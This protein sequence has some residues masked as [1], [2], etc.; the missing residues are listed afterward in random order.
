[1][2]TQNQDRLRIHFSSVPDTAH[3]DRW[4]GLWKEANFLPWDRGHAN[5]AL[6]DLLDQRSRPLSSPDPNPS[7]GAPPPNSESP[8]YASLLSALTSEGRRRRVLIPGCG[9]GYDVALFAAHGYDASGLEVS[10]HAADAARKYLEDPGKGPVEREYSVR[11]EKIGR[12]AMKVVSGDYF[13]DT[14]LKDVEGWD[15]DEGFDIIYDNTFLCALP[16]TLRP[17]WASRTA[18]LLRRPSP[19]SN[20][21][22]GVLICLEFPTHKPASSGGPPWS[23]PPLVHAELLKRPGQNIQYDDQGVVRKTDTEEMDNA[24]VKITH[25]TPKRTHDIGIIKGLVRD[26]VSM[27][28]HKADC[29][30]GARWH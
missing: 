4:D 7:L 29:P 28:R 14:W 1:M 13:E 18:S 12:G 10:S 27:W 3:N 25:Y 6:I 23:L 17:K 21:S 22:G 2:T 24:L 15:E 30:E 8:G 26:C 20:L 16:P 5:P 9:K 19:N 11:D